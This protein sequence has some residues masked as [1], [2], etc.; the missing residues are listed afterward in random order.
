MTL[1]M[2]DTLDLNTVPAPT[3]FEV[4]H[5]VIDQWKATHCPKGDFARETMMV[6]AR[7]R[8]WISARSVMAGVRD[9]FSACRLDGAALSPE[10]I[11]VLG[12][13]LARQ[14]AEQ[15]MLIAQPRRAG[16]LT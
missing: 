15:G 13:E 4:C 6:S 9:V 5:G 8:S 14:L 16:A 12:E 11:S 7:V 2:T 3:A 1:S 10:L